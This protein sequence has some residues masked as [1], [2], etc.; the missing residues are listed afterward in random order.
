MIQVQK[1]L[2]TKEQSRKHPRDLV[3]NY[4]GKDIGKKL[5]EEINSRLNFD[6]YSYLETIIIAS[7]NFISIKVYSVYIFGY[8]FDGD[9]IARNTLM[10]TYQQHGNFS[11]IGQHPKIPFSGKYDEALVK[12]K[13]FNVSYVDNNNF[14]YLINL[15]TNKPVWM[16][17]INNYVKVGNVW[18]LSSKTSCKLFTL[19]LYLQKLIK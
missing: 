19:K 13:H 15:N 18:Q 11:Y 16:R 17:I 1:V 14:L 10:F 4:V 5:I 9:E 7:P 3:I 8:D 12:Y 2:T 6:H